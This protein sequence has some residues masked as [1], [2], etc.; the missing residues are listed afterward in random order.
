M[1]GQTSADTERQRETTVNVAGTWHNQHGSEMH[2]VVEENGETFGT[3][4]TGVGAHKQNEEFNLA[5]FISQ[6]LIG[7]TVNFGKYCS[8]TSWTGQHTVEDGVEKIY[9]MWHLARAMP[10]TENPQGL[11]TG[12]LSGADVFYRG[13]AE[14]PVKGTAII[15]SHPISTRLIPG[16][17]Q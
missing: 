4:K 17:G 11:W 12:V 3:F 8:M 16:E 9:T 14:T 6:N 5:G 10:E 7:F 1:S 15:P 13:P 2:L